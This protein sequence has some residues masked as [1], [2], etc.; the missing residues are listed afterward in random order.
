MELNERKNQRTVEEHSRRESLKLQKINENYAKNEHQV[1]DFLNNTICNIKPS[2]SKS[3]A[4]KVEDVKAQSKAQLNIRNFKIEEDIKKVDISLK[5]L[6]Q[7]QARHA[8][9]TALHKN[10]QRQI[11]EHQSSLDHLQRSL[12]EVNKEQNSRRETSKLTIF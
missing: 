7:S 8:N 3:S 1:F 6:K 2:T 12:H 4:P 5:K 10:L 9:D 11:N